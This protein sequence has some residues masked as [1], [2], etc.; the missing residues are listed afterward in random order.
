[1]GV[2]VVSSKLEGARVGIDVQGKRQLDG[3]S[4]QAE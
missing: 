2:Q 3:A 1:M 4:A